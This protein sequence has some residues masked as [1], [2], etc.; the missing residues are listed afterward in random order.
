MHDVNALIEQHREYVRKL[1][2]EIHRKLPDRAIFDDLVGYGELGLVEAA[3]KFDPHAGAAFTTFAYYRIRGSIFDGIRKMS[4]LPPR[5]RKQ[6]TQ[7]AG[8]DQV[9]RSVAEAGIDPNAEPEELAG[10]FHEVVE[11]LGAVFLI[12]DLSPDDE[13][14]GSLDPADSAG[15]GER[16]AT[17]DLHAKVGKALSELPPE[18]MQLLDLFYFKQKSMTDI[19]AELGVHKA[20]ISRLH[21]KAI[22]SLQ[23]ALAGET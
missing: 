17:R 21:G 10:R 14:D 23:Q 4:W 6:V 16:M 11:R 7:D 15:P 19:A 12:T 8:A 9:G 3:Q 13:D 1:A 22:A 5:V 20:T 2:R 18:Q